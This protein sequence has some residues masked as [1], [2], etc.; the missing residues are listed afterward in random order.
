MGINSSSRFCIA[1]VMLALSGSAA[2]AG[3][4][5]AASPYAGEQQRAIKALSAQEV[6]DLPAGRGMG[7]SKV[8]ELNHFPGPAHVLELAAALQLS[9]AQVRQLRQQKEDMQQQAQRLG[10]E[11]IA[12][13]AALDAL[14]AARRTDDGTVRAMLADIGRL[15]GELRFVHVNAHLATTRLLSPQQVAAY[16]QMRGYTSDAP[17]THAH[18]H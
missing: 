4:S 2:I 18:H 11:I 13:E 1:A 6:A 15:Q 10:K 17:A 12:G 8:A 14:F 16:D 3:G 7:L 9:D 5:P